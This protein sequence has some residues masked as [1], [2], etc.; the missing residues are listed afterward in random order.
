MK[1]NI[2]NHAT[3]Q[4]QA[5]RLRLPPLRRRLRRAL[6]GHGRRPQRRRLQI[7]TR[8]NEMRFPHG[9]RKYGSTIII[10]IYISMGMHRSWWWRRGGAVHDDVVGVRVVV[11]IFNT[12]FKLVICPCMHQHFLTLVSTKYFF[13]F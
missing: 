4:M 11:P 8:Y 2:E 7:L 3:I 5:G 13:I 9:G 6:V 10:S 12:P 1:I